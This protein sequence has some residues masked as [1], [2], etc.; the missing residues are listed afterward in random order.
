MRRALQLAA[1]GRGRTSPNPMVGATI[2]AADGTIVGDGWHRQAGTPH[3]EI[4]ALA[5]AGPGAR[6]ATLLCTLEPC[7]H[8]GRTRPCTDAIIAAG[9]S[10]VVAAVEDPNPLM[11]GQGLAQLRAHGVEVTCDVESDASARLNAA[12]FMMMRQARPWVI[13]KAGVSIDGRVAAGLGVRTA[14]TSA[15]SLRRAQR[16]RAEVDAIAVGVE[17]VLIDDPLL[18]VREVFRPR[19]LI[20]VVLDRRLRTPPSSRMLSTLDSGPVLVVT[21][22]DALESCSEQAHRLA[23]AGATLVATDG[24]VPA[25]LGALAVRGVQS[26]LVEGGPKIHAAFSDAG[27]IDEVQVFVAQDVYLPDGLP[28]A[29]TVGLALASLDQVQVEVIGDDVLLRGYV[30]RPH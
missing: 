23:A 16:L 22:A 9:I 1:R 29:A 19:P 30:H 14:I 5:A 3:A 18:T 25:A 4:H 17:T 7:C 11:A 26:V 6:G 21:T 24:S 2:V 13:A 10:R 28:V 15:S 12:F 20:R 8:H 27:M